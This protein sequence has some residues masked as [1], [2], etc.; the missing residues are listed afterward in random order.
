MASLGADIRRSVR[1]MVESETRD[2]TEGAGS[3]AGFYDQLIERLRE[4]PGSARWAVVGFVAGAVF[5]HIVGFWH[6]VAVV[7]LKGP[8]PADQMAANNPVM[9]T[10][11]S[12]TRPAAASDLGAAGVSVPNCSALVL[13][14]NSGATHLSH[15]PPRISPVRHVAG[16][17][18]G[19]LGAKGRGVAGPGMIVDW[20]AIPLP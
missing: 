5:W 11:G 15:C 18:R 14:R 8:D 16:A 9:I 4:L 12:I 7:I 13:D 10:T 6:F 17:G 20:A 3:G 2:G 1:G 19:D